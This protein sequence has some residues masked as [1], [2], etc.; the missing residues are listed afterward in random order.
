VLRFLGHA[1][2]V[3]LVTGVAVVIGATIGNLT[4]DE[5]DAGDRIAGFLPDLG[6][7]SSDCLEYHILPGAAVGLV[8]GI[9]L[10]LGFALRDLQE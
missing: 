2:F 7:A 5:A 3:V 6:G 9:V 4:C 8:V 1:L 10:G